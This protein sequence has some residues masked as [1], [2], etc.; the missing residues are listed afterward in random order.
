MINHMTII[1]N[2]ESFKESNKIEVGSNTNKGKVLWMDNPYNNSDGTPADISVKTDEPSRSQSFS[3]H[4]LSELEIVEEP[5]MLEQKP[6]ETVEISN[7]KDLID[8]SD[9]MKIDIRVC[10]VIKAERVIGKD[11]LLILQ[12]DTGLDERQAV[13]NIGSIYEP[14]DLLNKS[15]AFVLNL[16]PAK[17]AKIDSH[18]MIMAAEVDG[19]PQIIE[20]KLPIGSKLI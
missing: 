1:K 7:L 5:K 3:W 9:L 4:K 17:I 15:F 12:I 16:K 20:M 14:E 10:K 13:T 2:Y 6:D 18:A 19:N 8:F 11:K